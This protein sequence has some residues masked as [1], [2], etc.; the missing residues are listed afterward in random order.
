MEKSKNKEKMEELLENLPVQTESS[1]Y[2]DREMILCKKCERKNPPNRL[3]C[4]YCGQE[5]EFSEAQIEYIKPGLRKLEVWEDGFNLIYLPEDSKAGNKK[6]SDISNYLG[7]E[8]EILEIIFESGK[9]LP[10]T[11][12]VSENEAEIF[13]KKL[14]GFGVKTIVLSDKMLNAKNPPKRIRRIRLYSDKIQ[15]VLFNQEKTVEFDVKDLSLIITGKI[16]ERR[17]E[18]VEKRNRKGENKIMQATETAFDEFLIDI[19]H[20]NDAIGFRILEKGFDFSCLGEEKELFASK[21]MP[22]LIE[23][24]KKLVDDGKF[25]DD[26]VRIREILGKVWEIENKTESQGF[27]RKGFGNLNFEN[28][29][30]ASNL[31]Q[32]T[33]YSRLRNHIL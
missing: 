33:K 32:F 13:Q 26:Y 1:A 6:L 24:L 10:L 21:N 8:S 12:V 3:K 29:S 17:V 28:L 9:S 30:T 31:T 25:V 27:K 20:R 7:I 4:L 11:R 19:Y 15:L 2:S 18:A 16:F 22:K 5:L 14:L 23:K